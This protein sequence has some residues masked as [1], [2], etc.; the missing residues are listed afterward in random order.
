LQVGRAGV[1]T[2]FGG[3]QPGVGCTSDGLAI[4]NF[5]HQHVQA[6]NKKAIGNFTNCL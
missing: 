5:D 4:L 6:R 2:L 3:R 1:A